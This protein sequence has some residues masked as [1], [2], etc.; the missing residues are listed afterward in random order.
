MKTGRT[1]IVAFFLLCIWGG[2]VY[3]ID[4]IIEDMG[5]F[6]SI[7]IIASLGAI[8]LI[9]FEI[10]RSVNTEMFEKVIGYETGEKEKIKIFL[11][12]IFLGSGYFLSFIA[13]SFFF[14][15][16]YRYISPFGLLSFFLRLIYVPISLMILSLIVRIFL[17][18]KID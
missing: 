3:E 17:K 11:V 5:T 7:S 15:T 9:F 6:D 14:F 13:I 18:E 12:K 10:S 1:I 16:L 4:N 2:M 8:S